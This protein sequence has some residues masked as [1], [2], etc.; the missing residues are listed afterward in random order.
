MYRQSRSKY[1]EDDYLNEEEDDDGE[2]VYLHD[3]RKYQLKRRPKCDKITGYALDVNKSKYAII[4]I[5]FDHK[6][7]EKIKE[8][9]RQN[10]LKVLKDDV[11]IEK[12]AHGGLHIYTIWDKS[13]PYKVNQNVK[14]CT[15]EGYDV[16]V[17][18][19]I[20]REAQCR[21]VIAGS[22]IRDGDAGPLLSYRLLRNCHPDNMASFDT[23]HKLLNKEFGID[24]KPPEN[25]ESNIAKIDPDKELEDFCEN[26]DE[27]YNGLI[28]GHCRSVNSMTKELF[29]AIYRGF[30]PVE[31]YDG[32]KPLTVNND[33]RP[34]SEEITMFTLISSLNA[35]IG[36]TVSFN[37]V[38]DALTYIYENADVSPSARAHWMDQTIRYRNSTAKHPGCLFRWL[39]T[40][41]PEYWKNVCK[42]LFPK[43]VISFK[44]S[45]A[46]VDDFIETLSPT[47]ELSQVITFLRQ[48][49]A[50]NTQGGY[51]IRDYDPETGNTRTNIYDYKQMVDKVGRI[52]VTY[53]TTEQERERMK[54]QKKKVEE[55]KE[56]KVSYLLNSTKYLE[57]FDKFRG[58]LLLTEDD[59]VFQ[60]FS[61]PRGEYDEYLM[62]E[63]LEFMYDR[64]DDKRAFDELLDSHAYRFRH[65]LTFIEKFFVSFG[66]SGHNCKSYLSACIA[67]AYNG[68]A[69]VGVSNRQIED[70]QFNSW[71]R[72]N[73]VVWLEEA[74]T[75]NY[76]T[77]N[78]Q[79][80]VKRM[81]TKFSSFRD[82]YK[83][84]QA[85][86]NWAIFGMNTNQP[87]LY[88]LIRGDSALKQRLVILNFKDGPA[89]NDKKA[90][91]ALDKKCKNMIEDPN[92]AYTMYYYLANVREINPE[93]SPV[94]YYGE[95]KNQFI[96]QAQLIKRNSVEDWLS[97]YGLDLFHQRN[98]RGVGEVMYITK[99]EASKSYKDYKDRHNNRL[100]LA[101][102]KET[103]LEHGFADKPMKFNVVTD[104]VDPE[105]G[106]YKTVTKN[107]DVF[108]MKKDDFDKLKAILRP[109]ARE[110]D[111]E[112][113]EDKNTPLPVLTEDGYYDRVMNDRS[114]E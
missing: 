3:Y 10:L 112:V 11:R 15:C 93:F 21:I 43:K 98:I 72:N 88:G 17:F 81:T 45:T 66:A 84:A 33:Y 4:D 24:L 77:K 97:E 8:S 73:L 90:L 32:N 67:Q 108:R 113:D 27:W 91:R 35:C 14:I 25:G 53:T 18:V 5:D 87:D 107:I 51:I 6:L 16:D 30:G 59:R 34:A 76:Q 109:E 101:Y 20:K 41:K 50:I 60:L 104:K 65:P 61:P 63:W 36:N 75:S 9:I 94:R 62:E 13:Q 47:M 49:V 106:E 1:D 22:K 55:Q 79:Q 99:P 105:T 100:C 110:E 7:D 64:F 42:P 44:G 28:T 40:L 86:R 89:D 83:T 96:R 102:I 70:D 111:V 95:D 71:I 56:V 39:K 103:M 78:M 57:H 68:L 54:E 114:D 19:P 23:I 29:V 2:F 82:M 85:G 38:Q 74:E 26:L 80:V 37:D 48:C 52:C 12:T 92:F 31:G 58:F 69:N 46:T